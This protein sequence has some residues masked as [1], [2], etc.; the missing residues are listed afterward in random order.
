MIMGKVETLDLAFSTLKSNVEV[1]I[2]SIIAIDFG[3]SFR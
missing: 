3:F 1:I 2:K